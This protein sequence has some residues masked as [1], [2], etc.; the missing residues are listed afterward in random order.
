MIVKT[1]TNP[2]IARY[3]RSVQQF[4]KVNTAFTPD[5]IVYCKAHY[6]FVPATENDEQ[7]LEQCKKLIID[8]KVQYGYLPKLVAL[9]GKG[10]MAIEE[11]HKSAL[12]VLDI[13]D[14][15]LKISFFSENFGGPK[16]MTPE[17]IEFIDHWEVENYRR[18]MAKNQG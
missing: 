7:M 9:E 6:L 5:N 14:D 4:E 2:L 12:N 13:F 17:Q 18:K 10:V 16:F 11:N 8:F 15:I 3:V 1:R